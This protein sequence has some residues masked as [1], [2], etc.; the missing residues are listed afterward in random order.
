MRRCVLLVSMLLLWFSIELVAQDAELDAE[1]DL[2]DPD[3]AATIGFS[4]ATG[5]FSGGVGS[6]KGI[7]GDEDDQGELL[8]PPRPVARSA[9]PW[10]LKLTSLPQACSNWLRLVTIKNIHEPVIW[11]VSDDELCLV[12]SVGIL[13][14]HS[15]DCLH[16]NNFLL[17]YTLGASAPEEK[18]VRESAHS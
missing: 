9:R 8:R 12:D 7:D 4:V 13:A 11:C 10:L 15:I 5:N 6:G 2:V 3:L 18:F 1:E 14:P 17:W 16:P